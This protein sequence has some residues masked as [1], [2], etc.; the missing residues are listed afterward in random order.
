MSKVITVSV[1]GIGQRGVAYSDSMIRFPDKYRIV[2]LCDCNQER[3]SARAPKYGVEKEHCFVDENEFFK[4]K[5]SDLLIIAT[6][7]RDHVRQ[8]ITALKLG[9]DILLEKPISPDI[10]DLY[11]LLEAHKK[12]GHKI[13]VCHVLRYSPAFEKAKE[14]VD[15]GALGQ[16]V[17]I[18][19]IENVQFEHQSH[20]FVRG[21]WRNKEETSPMILA[22][23]CHD[24]DLITWFANSQCNRVSSFG[25]LSFF[26]EENQPKGA[27]DRCLEC[28]FVDTCPYSAKVIYIKDQFW[29]RYI[30]TDANPNTDEAVLEA[31]KTGPYGRC[32]F[33][34]DNDVVDHQ[35]VTMQY[36][37]GVVGNLRMTAFMD[38]SGRVF[39]I[40]GTY[41]EL[42]INEDDDI[43][44]LR[45]FKDHERKI[46]RIHELGDTTSSA[47][48]G[49]DLRLVE[50][51]YDIITKNLEPKTSLEIS[52][53]SHL[54][55]L[56]SEES[57]LSNGASIEIKH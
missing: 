16:I 53:E 26:K 29:G 41:G 23:C 13:L 36:A 43:I 21:N 10:N 48:G 14:I 22:K 24:L 2:S 35:V 32:V 8:A 17:M 56:S 25:D 50:E 52:V 6:Q 3:L 57:R 5:R 1:L 42:R 12:Y 37:N 47:H 49:S 7:D 4:E 18:D 19:D 38:A 45:L 55:A 15:S 40:F 33:K 31:L 44:E 54:I 30:I 20:S 27:S 39:H 34:C 11:K 46:W 51:M 28:K 9:Y